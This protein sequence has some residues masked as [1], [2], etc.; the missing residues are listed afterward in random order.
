MIPTTPTFAR[1][2]S[3][4][5]V[6]IAIRRNESFLNRSVKPRCVVWCGLDWHGYQ[7]PL[8]ITVWGIEYPLIQPCDT[9]AKRCHPWFLGPVFRGSRMAG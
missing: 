7:P 2:S 3:F 5:D 1:S 6:R 8:P 9:Q 4:S